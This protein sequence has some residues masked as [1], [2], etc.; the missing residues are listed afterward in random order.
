MKEQKNGNRWM[1]PT[2]IVTVVLAIAGGA[3]AWGDSRTKTSENA[4]RITV[5]EKSINKLLEGQARIDERVKGM[6]RGQR[7]IKSDVKEILRELRSGR[8]PFR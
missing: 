5:N 6:Q 1:Q 4:R 7:E 3:A 8:G 2:L